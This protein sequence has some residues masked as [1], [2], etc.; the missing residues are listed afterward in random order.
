MEDST[1][2]GFV[3]AGNY[4]SIDFPFLKFALAKHKVMVYI[5]STETVLLE[6]QFA[7]KKDGGMFLF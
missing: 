5:V 1:E 6:N 3:S 4:S 7:L 2:K